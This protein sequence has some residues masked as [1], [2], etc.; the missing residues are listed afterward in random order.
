MASP[1]FNVES[2]L[3]FMGSLKSSAAY[4]GKKTPNVPEA[5]KA[6]VASM[7]H[8]ASEAPVTSNA[9]EVSKKQEAFKA[10][11]AQMT[12]LAQSALAMLEAVSI[13]KSFIYLGTIFRK[14]TQPFLSYSK[15]PGTGF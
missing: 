15:V 8:E 7:A 6:P 5:S 4:D 13:L 3:D 10:P 2:A 12:P 11:V 1:N 14:I 9:S